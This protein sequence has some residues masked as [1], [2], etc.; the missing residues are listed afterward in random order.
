MLVLVFSATKGIILMILYLLVMLLELPDS[1][2]EMIEC[3]IMFML[4]IL[5]I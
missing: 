2:M 5:V 3:L 1:G 4:L